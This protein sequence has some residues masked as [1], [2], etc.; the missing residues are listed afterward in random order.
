MSESRDDCR[1]S[2]VISEVRRESFEATWAGEPD[3]A[4]A[5]NNCAD[6]GDEGAEA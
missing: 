5:E 6:N 3:S 4:G 1:V 2:A